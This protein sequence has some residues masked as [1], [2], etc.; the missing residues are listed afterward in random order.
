M[1]KS[2]KKSS[3]VLIIVIVIAVLAILGRASFNFYKEK[4]MSEWD[5]QFG[6]DASGWTQEEKQRYNDYVEWL[7]DN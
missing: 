3:T 4:E 7:G 2:N 6:E 1:E 5:S